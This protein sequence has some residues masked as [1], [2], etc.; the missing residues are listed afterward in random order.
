VDWHRVRYDIWSGGYDWFV[1]IDAVSAARRRSLE[2]LDL[3]PGE[4]LLI[5]GCGTGLDFPFV[6]RGVEITAFDL[7]PRMVDHARSCAAALGLEARI[8]VGDAMRLP[9][10]D[11]SFD[12]V[13]LHLILAIVADPRASLREAA[14][15][16]RP[17][18]RV[19]V[20]D[21]FVPG[22]SCR[23]GLV[24]RALNVP[25]RL[26]FTDLTRCL[27]PLVA[28]SPFAIAYQ[29]PSLLRGQFRIAQLRHAAEAAERA[30][31]AGAGAPA[32]PAPGAPAAPAPVHG[33]G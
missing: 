3:Q 26:L 16:L 10:V 14:R 27:E 5:D 28:G 15:V 13:L 6:P 23:P 24:R 7:S 11:G 29:E 20:F 4:K 18:G 2:L 19:A 31:A 1:G 17:G 8:E 22:D 9:Y 21:K 33:P 25:A 32:A 12:A 30:V